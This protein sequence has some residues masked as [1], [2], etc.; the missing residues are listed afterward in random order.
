MLNNDELV[1]QECAKKWKNRE[2]EVALIKRADTFVEL[3]GY[4]FPRSE[5]V[6]LSPSRFPGKLNRAN[7]ASIIAGITRKYE[8]K[9]TARVKSRRRLCAHRK[10][11]C[12]PRLTRCKR[13]PRC[14]LHLSLS[15]CRAPLQATAGTDCEFTA[16]LTV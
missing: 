14:N 2:E 1:I 9:V 4:K 10:F 16:S 3:R 5:V 7:D 6:W 12:L 8:H 13:S 15:L 11:H